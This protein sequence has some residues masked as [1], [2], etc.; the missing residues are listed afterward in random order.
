MLT[1]ILFAIL[2]RARGSHFWNLVPSTTASRLL[3]TLGMAT[4]IVAQTGDARLFALW[5]L[6]FLW[7]LFGWDTFWAAII[8]D[9]PNHSKL[10][11]LSR[12]GLR[13]LLAAPAIAF[14][15]YLTN[16]HILWALATPLLDLP[17]LLFGAINKSSAIE[18][19][20]PTDGALL[21]II[22]SLAMS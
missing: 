22:F 5:P 10:W 8:G 14:A 2:N 9:D 18:R 21:C 17:Y 13:M 4:V 3:A 16:G 19:A 11:G 6:L 15:A 1:V 12:M 20:E 7:S